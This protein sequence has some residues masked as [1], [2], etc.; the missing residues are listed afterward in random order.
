M[1]GLGALVIGL[2]GMWFVT[3]IIE[4]IARLFGYTWE[5]PQSVDD[6]IREALFSDYWEDEDD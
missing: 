4:R 3:L 1:E 2:G 5:L 6:E